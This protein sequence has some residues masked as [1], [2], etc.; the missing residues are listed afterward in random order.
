[1]YLE[2]Q[3]AYT[4]SDFITDIYKMNAIL[5]C[6]P[7]TETYSFTLKKNNPDATFLKLHSNKISILFN[8]NI[9]G[10]PEHT[11]DISNSF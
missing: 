8:V 5:F 1:M 3:L 10:Q 6:T 2:G 7:K 11:G 9:M 4:G